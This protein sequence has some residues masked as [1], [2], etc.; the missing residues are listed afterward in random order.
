MKIAV[1]ITRVLLG[2]PF[3]IFG[4]NGVAMYLGKTLIAL[5]PPEEA[6]AGSFMAALFQ[7]KFGLV[8]KLLEIAGGLMLISGRLVP[9]GLVLV[10]PIAVNILLYHLF[11]AKD[12]AGPG[13]MGVVLVLLLG[14]LVW[15][16]RSS[17]S[18]VWNAKAAPTV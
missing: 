1:I 15:A 12:L 7:T 6:L 13:A 4:I 18:G 10:G 2:L 11:L 5:P 14:F 16:Y 17:F 8:V 3:V 9:L